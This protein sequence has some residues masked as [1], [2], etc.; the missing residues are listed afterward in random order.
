MVVVVA[1][2]LEVVCSSTVVIGS[3]VREDNNLH[4]SYGLNNL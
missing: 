3:G 1:V 4:N 2:V